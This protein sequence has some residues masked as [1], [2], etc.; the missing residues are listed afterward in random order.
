M[1]YQIKVTSA[2]GELTVESSGD[3]PEG[4]HYVSGHEDASNRS[5][6]VSRTD[7]DGKSLIQASAGHP[8]GV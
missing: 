5:L 7:K 6:S 8:K 1:S 3:V 4:A 2:G